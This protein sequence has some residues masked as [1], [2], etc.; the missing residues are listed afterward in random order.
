MSVGF[1]GL[2]N[3]GLP[4]AR[5]MLDAGI[6]LVVW[7]RTAERSERLRERDAVVAES[8][9]ALFG[10]CAA[11][12]AMLVDAQALDAVLGRNTPAFARRLRGRTLVALGTTAADYSRAL[13]SDIRACGGRYVEAPVSGSRGP[14]EA[15][16]LVGM[17]AGD[18]DAV[19]L[20][21]PLLAPFCREVFACGAVPA[22]LRMKLA[23]NH[24]LIAMVAALAEAAQAAEGSGVDLD[25]F[26]RVLDAGPMASDV[27][28]SKLDK[29]LQRDFSPQAAIHDVAGIARL[30]REQARAAGVDA[31]LIDAA[32][33]MFDDA[34][35]RGL[36]PLDMAAV[37][38][39]AAALP[40]PLAPSDSARH[41]T[42]SGAPACKRSASSRSPC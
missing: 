6:P 9:D 12:L 35:R 11:V 37:L 36:A 20:A 23:V 40:A 33:R 15:G 3:M 28:R 8:L 41:P 18:P 4:M 22:A 5:R 24:Y 17:V 16:A 13:A 38:Q 29:L 21:S 10:S 27:S 42:T 25:T 14:A 31:P 19:A 39:P 2:G 26:R 7:N 34:L 1:I 30:A 32:A